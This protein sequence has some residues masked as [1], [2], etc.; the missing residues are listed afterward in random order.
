[1][2]PKKPSA[3]TFFGIPTHSSL[4]T[5]LSFLPQLILAWSE[6]TYTQ[7]IKECYDAMIMHCKNDW[8]RLNKSFYSNA[9]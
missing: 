5:Q 4:Y 9:R 8:Q 3:L 6:S 1:M 2:E 7:I